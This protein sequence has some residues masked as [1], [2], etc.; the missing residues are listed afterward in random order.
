MT[1]LDRQMKRD[2]KSLVLIHQLYINLIISNLLQDNLCD[3]ST[4]AN[5][6]LCRKTGHF[7]FQI[8]FLTLDDVYFTTKLRVPLQAR[9]KLQ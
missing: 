1:S 3:I 7:H 4:I 9:R 2:I 8:L 5:V 6:Y